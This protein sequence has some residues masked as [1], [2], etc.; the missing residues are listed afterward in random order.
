M[1]D[2]NNKERKKYNLKK[3]SVLN[4]WFSDVFEGHYK[5]A[6]AWN[7]LKLIIQI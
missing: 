2:A 6:L 1:Q 3:C 7:G 4:H 5:G